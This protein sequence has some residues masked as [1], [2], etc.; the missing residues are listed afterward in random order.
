[1]WTKADGYPIFSDTPNYKYI[2]IENLN[3][4]KFIDEI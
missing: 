3:E 4:I 1:M 2:K